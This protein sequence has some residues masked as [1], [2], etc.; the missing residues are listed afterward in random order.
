[1]EP[2]Y[3][4]QN[5]LINAI[6]HGDVDKISEIVKSD[7]FADFMKAGCEDYR[8]S[9]SWLSYIYP[10]DNAEV[11]LTLLDGIENNNFYD[12]AF[13]E[14]CDKGLSNIFNVLLEHPR[15][16]NLHITHAGKHNMPAYVTLSLQNNKEFLF[17]LVESERFNHNFMFSIIF[18]YAQ[19]EYFQ[20]ITDDALYDMLQLLLEYKAVDLN[21]QFSFSNR[22]SA[23]HIVCRR[24]F[25]K[26]LKLLLDE[27]QIDPN[28]YNDQ[29]LT[30]F[31]VAIKYGTLE[32]I[33]YMMENSRVDIR[34]FDKQKR[35]A[36]ELLCDENYQKV[37]FFIQESMT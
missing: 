12:E 36:L 9:D 29:G 24:H 30:P 1:M 33:K 15:V 34:N 31:G 5:E 19:D 4:F 27:V 22:D 37:N 32:I 7:D 10:T 21:Q 28:I 2:Y 14:A 6:K 20:K 3:D 8:I 25:F 35:S 16:V 23:L 18:V 17:K 11:L 26:C 13:L